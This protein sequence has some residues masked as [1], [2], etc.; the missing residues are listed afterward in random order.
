MHK[1]IVLALKN[2]HKAGQIAKE[3]LENLIKRGMITQADFDEIVA[4][5]TF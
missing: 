3:Q 5:V 4:E 1:L 2:M